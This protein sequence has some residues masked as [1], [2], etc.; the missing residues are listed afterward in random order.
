MPPTLRVRLPGWRTS[1]WIWV[2]VSV[3]AMGLLA[4]IRLF[5]LHDFLVPL[6]YGLPLLIALIHRWRRLLYAMAVAMTLIS[7]FKVFYIYPAAA[8]RSAYD[9][10]AFVMM[11]ASIWIEAGVIDFLI[12]SRGQLEAHAIA[13]EA[14]NVRLEQANAELAEREVEISRQNEELHCQSEELTGQNDELQRRA[15]ELHIVTTELRQANETLRRRGQG[16][17]SLIECARFLASDVRESRVMPMLCQAL[18]ELVGPPAAGAA[19]IE[20]RRDQLHLRGCAGFEPASADD[21]NTDSSFASIV[22]KTGRTAALPDTALRPDLR[23]AAPATGDR[24]GAVLAAPL[25]AN[26][27]IIGVLE[28]YARLPCEWPAQSFH[29][30]EWFAAQAALVLEAVELNTELDRR[31]AEAVEASVH[32]TRFLAAVSHDVRTPVNAISLMAEVISRAADG[33]EVDTHVGELA[34]ELKSAA[35][36]LADLVTDVLDVAR[37]DSGQIE[38]ASNIFV[39]DDFVATEARTLRPLATTKGIELA[40]DLPRE[41]L[42]VRTDRIK[43]SRVV[44]NLVGNAIKFTEHGSVR[45]QIAAVPGGGATLRVIDTGP[46]I[47]AAHLPQIFDE[48]FQLRNPER[49]RSKGTGLGLAICKRLAAALGCVLSVE[50]VLGGGTTFSIGIPPELCATAADLPVQGRMSVHMTKPEQP[51]GVLAGRTIL[52]VE[53]HHTTRRATAHLLQ[54]EGAHVLT[55]ENGRDAL[56]ILAH[57]APE[58]LLLDLMMPVMDGA[59]VLQALATT[60]KESLRY[61]FA[62]SGDVTAARRKQVTA[63]GADGLIAK[64]IAINDL[65]ATLEAGAEVV[66]A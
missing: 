18:L 53:D 49:D 65:I 63:L 27:K 59:D 54:A 43:L 42:V 1:L 38:V 3:V 57:E 17:S 6:A 9:M 11:L 60:R 12:R 13:V 28:V 25:R 36:S 51:G 4:W 21:W 5:L 16:L 37:F 66:G 33:P 39:L 10:T 40:V 35:R 26:G 24:F 50:S 15:A 58:I 47:P 7:F 30:I 48:F 52:L 46:G 56:Q 8:G 29:L 22:M 62:I 14:A 61:I 2:P 31:R 55:A 20:C 23:V 32:K 34:R 44:A 45:I 64:P 41:R 19:I